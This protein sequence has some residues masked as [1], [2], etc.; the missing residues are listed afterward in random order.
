MTVLCD[1]WDQDGVEKDSKLVAISA[2]GVLYLP[3][4]L[5]ISIWGNRYFECDT[6][7]FS[8]TTVL[9]SRCY[10]SSECSD[11]ASTRGGEVST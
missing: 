11:F 1:R 8:L 5:I 4:F 7:W 2:A 3:S 9:I 6:H 10:I